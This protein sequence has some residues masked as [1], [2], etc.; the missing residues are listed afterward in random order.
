MG[1]AVHDADA[2]GQDSSGWSGAEPEVDGT[3][4][5]VRAIRRHLI[6]IVACTLFVALAG[7]LVGQRVG[8]QYEATTSVLLHPLRG[9]PYTTE[10]RGDD[11]ANL[12]TEAQLVNTD[13][14]IELARDRLDTEQAPERIR[15]RVS[16]DVP[17]NTQVLELTYTARDPEQARAGA[18]V[19]AETYLD[20]RRQR[21]QQAIDNQLTGLDGQRASVQQQFDETTAE[22][23]TVGADATRRTY[24]EERISALAGQLS[25]LE[26]EQ[27]MLAATDLEPGQIL[28][29]AR[30]PDAASGLPT[31]V[32]VA[33]G[34]LAG[35]LIGLVTA[36]ILACT[37]RRV[38]EPVQLA[39]LGFAPL[40]TV[41]RAERTTPPLAWLDSP[42]GESPPALPVPYRMLR[43]RV[44]AAD[45]QPPAVIGVVTDHADTA[46]APEASALA[47]GLSRA[48][49]TV[50]LVDTRG[51]VAPLL[52]DD[53]EATP[54]LAELLD[55]SAELVDLIHP[56]SATL[57]VLPVGTNPAGVADRL[58]SRPMRTL[59]ANLRARCD[60]V[61]IAGTD[62]AA[63]E[64][65]AI[66]VLADTT[67]VLVTRAK[68]TRA[69]LDELHG[70]LRS[71]DGDILGAVFVE[72]VP[73]APTAATSRR[74]GAQPDEHP[75]QLAQRSDH[76]GDEQPGTPSSL[77]RA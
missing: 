58:L 53:T 30:R 62:G 38:R 43:A 23:A 68:A 71:V 59:V 6:L 2:L 70:A 37:D 73:L 28:S 46:C 55:Q 17:T 61:V 25:T 1:S 63:P 13:A 52:T 22:L 29:P 21:A 33:A 45:H 26:T 3:E 4:L 5:L 15:T 8:D 48:G 75:E 31:A 65:Q 18:E 72:P 54:G 56:V 27:S 60:F 51:D 66:A 67:L 20:Y 47:A 24:L 19:F 14:V 11:L 39:R 34:A 57:G 12:E 74:S 36:L 50:A 42:D 35:L 69:R 40:A 9:N 77:F 10:E 44:L 41:P 49:F 64:G 32:F 7:L 76:H 16:V